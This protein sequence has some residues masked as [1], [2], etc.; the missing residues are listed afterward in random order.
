MQTN[1]LILRNVA[2]IAICFVVT[3]MFVLCEKEDNKQKGGNI[4]G[5]WMFVD[6]DGVTLEIT[7][8]EIMLLPVVPNP[9]PMETRTYSWVSS[10][11]VE[12][13]HN[14]CRLQNVASHCKVIF[15]TKDSVTIQNWFWNCNEVDVPIY[16]DITIERITD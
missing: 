13:I 11:S 1:G 12:I 16:A 6:R 8:S 15:H 14:V 3:I 2:A 7:K 4:E 5:K 9:V 10:D